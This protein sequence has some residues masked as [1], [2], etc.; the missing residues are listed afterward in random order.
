MGLKQDKLAEKVGLDKGSVGNLCSGTRRPSYEV[1]RKL[2]L[3]GA[4]IDEVFDEE[5]LEAVRKSSGGAAPAV[6]TGYDSPEFLEGVANAIRLMR[7]KGMMP[8]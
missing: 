3:L 5:T 6:P 4:R 2:L 7:E 1:I 8:R